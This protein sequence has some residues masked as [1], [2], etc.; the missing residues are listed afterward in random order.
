MK[1]IPILIF[2]LL[3]VLSCEKK[4][5]IDM[6]QQDPKIVINALF[7]NTKKFSAMISSSAM[8]DDEFGPHAIANAIVELYENETFVDTLTYT[9]EGIYQFNDTL[10]PGNTYRLNVTCDLGSASAIATMPEAV[11]IISVDSIVK[12]QIVNDVWGE[13]WEAL[14]VYYTFQDQPGNQYY[15]LKFIARSQYESL[16]YSDFGNLFYYEYNYRTSSGVFNETGSVDLYEYLRFSDGLFDQELKTYKFGIQYEPYDIQS[17][18]EN[19]YLFTMRFYTLSESFYT[20]L[21]TLEVYYNADEDIFAEIINLYS[22]VEGGLGIFA[23]AAMYEVDVDLSG[24][25]YK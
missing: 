2:I 25:T 15:S 24:I 7:D 21:Q 4:I 8:I 13:T 1:K 22:N 17:Y 20:Y 16:G 3:I 12:A 11:P 23:G 18:I 19:D 10:K 5:P 9:G 6:E 14:M